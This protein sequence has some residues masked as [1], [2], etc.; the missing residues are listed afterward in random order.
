MIYI[1][2][3]IYVFAISIGSCS[4]LLCFLVDKLYSLEVNRSH[5]V[6]FTAL[7]GLLFGDIILNYFYWFG[8]HKIEDKWIPLFLNFGVN[9]A[10]CAL[11]Y[12]IPLF[13]LSLVG[14]KNRITLFLIFKRLSISLFACLC[15]VYGFK[16]F[17][18]LNLSFDLSYFI[19][20][21]LI[22][23]IEVIWSIF[24]CFNAQKEMSDS[25]L[26]KVIKIILVLCSFFVVGFFID[27]FRVKLG[28]FPQLES[29][30]FYSIFYLL[31]SIIYC[32]SVYKLIIEKLPLQQASNTESLFESFNITEREKDIAK[33]IAKGLS[34][35]EIGEALFISEYTVKRHIQNIFGK[36][37]VTNRISILK[38]LEIDSFNSF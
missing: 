8:F 21:D 38:K 3:I 24:I 23:F 35:A 6:F 22:L 26:S 1:Q 2:S 4:L 29:F 33:Q 11:V 19:I 10:Q 7:T 14:F 13:I 37:K 5:K 25:F 32:V 30:R 17:N 28:V 36:L 31:W 16:I 20:L 34:N 9:I 27:L 18:R 12:A 15:L